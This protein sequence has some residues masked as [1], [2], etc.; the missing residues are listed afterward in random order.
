M[1]AS[2]HSP[3]PIQEKHWKTVGMVGHDRLTGDIGR[4]RISRKYTL[5][6][7]RLPPVEGH[8]IGPMLLDGHQGPRQVEA[9]LIG[10]LLPP[11]HHQLGIGR[12]AEPHRAERSGAEPVSGGKPVDA[13]DGS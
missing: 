13:D 6:T 11:L 12:A 9:Q 5:P 1:S 10:E 2:D 7:L 3:A 8:D 4:K